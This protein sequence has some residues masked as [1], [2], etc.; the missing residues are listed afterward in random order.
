[1]Y[2]YRT[3]TLGTKVYCLV[4]VVVVVVLILDN[5]SEAAALVK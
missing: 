2:M 3:H 1:M 4:V 5:C